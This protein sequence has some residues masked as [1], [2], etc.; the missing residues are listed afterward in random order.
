MKSKT[1]VS[2]LFTPL[3]SWV[4]AGGVAAVEIVNLA[5]AT[6]GRTGICVTEMDG[7]ERVEIPLTVL[8]TVS[9][10]SPDG[11][12]VLVRLD[13][14]RFRE[15]GIIA[16]MSGS[17]VY[18]DGKLLG[19]LAF[20]WPFATEPIGGV[21]PIERMLEIEPLPIVPPDAPRL[22]LAQVLAA[23]ND[24]ELGRLILDRLLPDEMGSIQPLP[25]TVTVGGWAAPSTGSWLAE[26]WRRLGWVAAPGGGATA[27]AAGGVVSPGSMVA[28]VLVDGDVTIAAAGTVTEVRG[29][30]LWAFGHSS[31]G[32]GTVS[33]PMARAHVVAVLPSLMSSF[34]FFT[35][36]QPV[37]AIIADRRPGV[38][39]RIG[40]DAPTLPITV[41][42]DDR[43]FSFRSLRH[44]VLTPL[45]VGYLAQTSQ[46]ALGRTFGEQ[47]VSTRVT[48]RYRGQVPATVG[49][50][51]ATAVVAY[52]EGSS[53]APA[54]LETVDIAI[55]TVEDL[56]TAAIVDV[57]PERRVVN[58]GDDLAVHFRLRRRRGPEE[59]RTMTVHIPEG[60]PEGRLDLVGADGAAWTAYNLQMRPYEPS[61]FADEIRLVNSLIPSTVLV[62]ILERQDVGMVI[63]GG[64][65]SAPP[66]IVMQT[67][68]ALGPNLETVAYSVVAEVETEMPFPV[69]GAQRIPLTVIAGIRESETQ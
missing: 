26:S 25:L 65:I 43:V 28:A 58:P 51:F 55:D 47:T 12:M 64:S 32:A 23:A 67:Q 61:S 9:S 22:E 24:G 16:G 3:L 14:P 11:E 49:A 57:V 38:L 1:L 5:D 27:T 40:V 8:G 37:G 48:L 36:G 18:L 33:M 52:L 13:A 29:D 7:G 59:T 4:A 54:E 19:A 50:T 68:S 21:T 53:Y 20:G 46:G 39:G 30:R 15:T 31:L 2:I 63:Q 69:T 62:A 66:S 45:L 34:K 35:V 17:P 42:V 60:I 41:R 56:R 44:P 6:P 10:G